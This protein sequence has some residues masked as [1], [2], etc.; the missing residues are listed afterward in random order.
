MG[1]SVPFGMW[2]FNDMIFA[3][4]GPKRKTVLSDSRG[5]TAVEF[6]FVG[7]IFIVTVLFVLQFALQLFAQ[8]VLDIGTAAGSRDVEIGVITGAAGG[9]NDATFH[10]D[11]CKYASYMVKN[12]Q[13]SVVLKPTYGTTF[14]GSMG[15][16]YGVAN[17][18]VMITATYHMPYITPLIGKVVGG[19]GQDLV[20]VNSFLN[21]PY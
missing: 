15:S 20:S 13:T 8:A 7:P 17:S 9:S 3:R 19:T 11:L 4:R 10:T 2:I 12:C 6:A 5:V 1:R 16:G 14:S 21:E 18:A